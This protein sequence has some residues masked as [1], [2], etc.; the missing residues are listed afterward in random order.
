VDEAQ[1]PLLTEL[2]KLRAQIDEFEGK[3]AAIAV[4][5]LVPLTR[6]RVLIFA[7]TDSN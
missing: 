1:K 3:R 5:L 7:W 2:N 6:T 4:I